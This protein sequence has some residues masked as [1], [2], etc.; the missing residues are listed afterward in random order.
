MFYKSIDL[1]V[2]VFTNFFVKFLKQYSIKILLNMTLSVSEVDACYNE[3]L[4]TLNAYLFLYA[5]SKSVFKFLSTYKIDFFANFLVSEFNVLNPPSLKS[6][7]NRFQ[8][9]AVL[10][11][12]NFLYNLKWNPP[13]FS[14]G[15]N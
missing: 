5:K 1:N 11:L 15:L 12:E 2:K 14:R 8:L 10:N 4:K 7:K 9:S 6:S 3:N 13:Y